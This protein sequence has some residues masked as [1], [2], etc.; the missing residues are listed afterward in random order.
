MEPLID[1][2]DAGVGLRRCGW[3]GTAP[4]YVRYH[5]EE[6]GVP[7]TGDVAYY[8]RL[9]F[10]SFQSGLSWLIIMRKRPAFR[11]AF[12]GFQPEVVAEFGDDDVQRLLADAGIV[13]NRQKIQAAIANARALRALREAHGEGALERL[14]LAHAP[15]DDD[16]RREGFNRPPRRLDDLA[17]A[18]AASRALAKAL[19]AKGFVFVG[20]TTLH[21]GMQANGL[22]DDHIEGCFRRGVARTLSHP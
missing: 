17:T 10:E 12:A 6:W 11:L 8:E 18:T 5:D 7:V 2:S 1:A 16:L 20:P 15:S 19:K 4:D 3:P 9:T 14:M 21:A 13:R 22:L